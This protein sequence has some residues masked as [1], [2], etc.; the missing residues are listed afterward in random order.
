MKKYKI[1]VL[2]DYQNAALDSAD[3]R[4]GELN[5]DNRYDRMTDSF[6]R[7]VGRA[8]ISAIEFARSHAAALTPG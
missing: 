8:P 6:Q 2:D 3:W 7:L 4:M 1:A 5:R